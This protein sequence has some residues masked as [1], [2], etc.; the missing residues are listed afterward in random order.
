MSAGFRTLNYLGSKLRL[1]NF[2]DGNVGKITRDGAG[3]CDL[4][5]GSGCV[6][7]RLSQRFPI[8][9]CDI[10]N[11]SKVIVNALLR[12]YEDV[13]HK[14]ES[15]FKTLDVKCSGRVLE[16]FKPLIAFEENAI[17]NKDSQSLTDVVEHGSVEVFNI[18]HAASPID[19]LLL[20]VS[21][22]LHRQGID[23]ERT[24]VSRYYGGVYFSYRQAV[25]MDILLEHIFTQVSSFD[26]DI[27][28][29]ALLSTASDVVDTVGK[30]FAQ[31]I[32]ARDSKGNIKSIV[33]NK[34]LKD[35]T[36]D[37]MELYK[38]WL[39]R[40][41]LL[42]RSCNNSVVFQG[43][44]LDC[45]ESLTDDVETIY[46]DPPYTREHYSRFYHVL[47]TISFRDSPKVSMVKTHGETHVSN[48]IYRAER[49]QSP[50]CIKSQALEMFD[51]M[52]ELSS[53]KGKKLLLSYSPYDR[54]KN[55]HP[56]VVTIEQLIDIAEKYYR[57][58][59]L[60]S[61]GTFHHNKLNSVEHK[62][63]AA[64]EAELLIVS[65]NVR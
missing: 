29:A 27:F 18:E 36:V 11:Y 14:V 38:E 42:P 49:F 40:Y 47:E 23:D 33:C 4:F 30:H 41:A 16:A 62:L 39:M 53:Q 31:P 52:F 7:Y 5:A 43:D 28:L 45:L 55:S 8:V 59:E 20:K 34:A 21:N 44:C 17:R 35:K 9:S 64:D 1:L 51:K 56:R 50:F 54:F 10:Q 57:N 12:K 63:E 61:A 15:F 22:A 25:Q 24:L 13:P 26:R 60:V 3:V 37:V 46:A 6:S 32:R 19:G 58:V 48:G 2:I 65:T